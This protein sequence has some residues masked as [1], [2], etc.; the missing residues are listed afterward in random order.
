[1]FTN[2]YLDYVDGEVAR[3]RKEITGIGFFTEKFVHG[4]ECGTFYLVWG[5][6][7]S[8]LTDNFGYALIGASAT[9]LYLLT[10]ISKRSIFAYSV[11]W[12]VPEIMDYEPYPQWDA[13]Q[14]KVNTIMKVYGSLP[15]VLLFV[16]MNRLELFIILYSCLECG[17]FLITS[18]INAQKYSYIVKI[19]PRNV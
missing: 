12:D 3:F 5:L 15:H 7:L 6:H 13:I 10:D 17:N 16:I 8:L 19:K 1:M 9:I 14:D 18:M 4:I 2:F 11:N